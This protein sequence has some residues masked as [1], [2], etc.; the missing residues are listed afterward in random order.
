MTDAM[1]EGPEK[2]IGNVTAW[3]R[4]FVPIKYV[5]FPIA[6]SHPLPDSNVLQT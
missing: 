1:I 4:V 6:H 2:E 5:R 3:L